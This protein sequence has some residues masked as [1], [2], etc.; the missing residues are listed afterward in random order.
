M[1]CLQELKAHKEDCI[2]L[3]QRIA[4]LLHPVAEILQDQNY[5][6]LEPRFQA[7]L[8]RFQKCVISILIHGA[9]D[10]SSYRELENILDTLRAQSNCSNVQR[11]RIIISGST[12]NESI[13]KCKELV[14]QVCQ[15]FSV[16]SSI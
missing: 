3:A 10:L 1:A 15:K 16:S 14:D 12:G 6:D 13:A 11:F 2:E 9:T 8:I 4:G 5:A 7:D